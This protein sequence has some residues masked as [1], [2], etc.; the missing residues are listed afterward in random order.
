MRKIIAT[1]AAT[2]TLAGGGLAIAAVNPFSG[3]GATTQATT[4]T[5]TSTAPA[6]TG[7]TTKAGRPGAGILRSVLDDLVAKGTITQAQADAVTSGVKAKAAAVRAERPGRPGRPGSRRYALRGTIEVS[8]KAIGVST[9]DLKAALEDGTSIADVATSKNVDPQTVIDAL[10][11][12]STTRIDAAVKDG[13]LTAERATA[14]KAKLPDIAK[15]VVNA[16]RQPR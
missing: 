16:S 14:L 5:A 8:A 6:T 13:K 12:A 2:L 9:D 3:A 11:Q 10:V 1:T 7:D 15:R 4:T